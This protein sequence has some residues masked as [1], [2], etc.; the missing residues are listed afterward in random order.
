MTTRRV[1]RYLHASDDDQLDLSLW[2]VD[3]PQHDVYHYSLYEV[4]VELEVEM[5]TGKSR[6]V[7]VN[8]VELVEPAPFR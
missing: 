1:T 3:A 6:I 8:G 4:Q 5:E 7:A 2:P